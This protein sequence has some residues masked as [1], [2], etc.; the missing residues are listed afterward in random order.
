MD[1]KPVGR[2]F[3]ADAFGDPAYNV[4]SLEAAV[5]DMRNYIASTVPEMGST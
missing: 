3:N 4:P 1:K 5:V 2:P